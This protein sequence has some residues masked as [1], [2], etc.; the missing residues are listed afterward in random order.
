MGFSHPQRE[1]FPWGWEFLKNPLFEERKCSWAPLPNTAPP[2]TQPSSDFPTKLWKELPLAFNIGSSFAMFPQHPSPQTRLITTTNLWKLL[3]R[4]FFLFQ[5][6][7][8]SPLFLLPLSLSTRRNHFSTFC[9]KQANTRI[10]TTKK[11]H[12]V[13][14]IHLMSQ[15]LK[16]WFA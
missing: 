7:G 4:A 12:Q 6:K 8:I 11:C 14:S 3:E 9:R 2:I 13:T 16:N 5:R 1:W 10:K 15:G